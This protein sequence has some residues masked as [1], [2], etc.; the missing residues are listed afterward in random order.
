MRRVRERV[1]SH[2]ISCTARE[3]E[4]VRERATDAGTS[5]SRYVVDRI[6][7]SPDPDAGGDAIALSG[8]EQRAMHDALLRT[9][10]L[11]ERL[12]A[13]GDGVDVAS[14]VALLFE[15][16]LDEMVRTGRLEELRGILSAIVGEERA[17]RIAGRAWERVRGRQDAG[18]P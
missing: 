16:R 7:N 8:H 14:G 5:L 1:T 10:A 15:A 11:V 9:E 6:L 4:T 2:S 17:A 18:P 12:V 3:W 13:A